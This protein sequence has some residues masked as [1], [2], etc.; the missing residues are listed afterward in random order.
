MKKQIYAVLNLSVYFWLHMIRKL[1]RIF[2]PPEGLL[3]F[4]ENYREDNVFSLSAEERALLIEFQR[5]I[6]CGICSI[7]PPGMEGGFSPQ[8][9]AT[10]LS[11]SL[12]ELWAIRDI[13]SPLGDCSS[14]KLNC[15]YAVPLEKIVE[16]IK[17]HSSKNSNGQ[18]PIG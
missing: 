5:C 18:I 2:R 16:F 6:G 13:I 11:R 1:Y 9:F 10:T 8:E 14:W 7:N 15:P 3:Q 17:R 12:P 4:Q